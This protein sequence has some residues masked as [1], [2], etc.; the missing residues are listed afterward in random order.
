[1][2]I[3]WAMAIILFGTFDIKKLLISYQFNA[4]I[5]LIILQNM[6]VL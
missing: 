2:F 6:D 4:A 3:S 5:F 1:M